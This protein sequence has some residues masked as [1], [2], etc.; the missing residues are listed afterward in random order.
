MPDFWSLRAFRTIAEQGSLSR[1]ATLLEVSQSKLSRRLAQLERE[2]G[3]SLFY[4]NGRGVLLT[5]LG[6][7]LRP[8]ADGLLVDL[9]G[10]LAAARDQ[11]TNPAGEV[12]IG[13]VRAVGHPLPS[14]V[15]K[16]VAAEFPRIRLR[17]HQAYSGHVEDALG[18]G[19]IDI[20]IFNRYRRGKLRAGEF[21]FRT[22]MVVVRAKSAGKPFG[23]EIPFAALAGLPLACPL[24]PN[25]LTAALED[26]A[27]RRGL[28]LDMAVEAGTSEIVRDL[29]ARAGY[30]NVL[31][32]HVALSEYASR[33]FVISTL[34][35]PQIEQ[36][37]WLA[38]TTQRPASQ[39]AR[40]VA[41]I[42]RETCRELLRDGTWKGPR[43]A[44]DG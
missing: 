10:L 28:R 2:V 22:D 39:A 35:K 32:R 16:R 36:T 27:N 34:V 31:P 24:R 20:G 9:D 26:I 18:H 29:V 4:R 6:Q 17:F 23:S 43:L 1:A 12:D 21:L 3:G 40:I 37:T 5:E 14:R 11:K 38:M 44:A 13:L 25:P 7:Q 30:A 41:R 42:L 8:H 15:A 33:D 19:R